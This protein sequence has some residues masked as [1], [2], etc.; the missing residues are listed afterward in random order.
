MSEG[1]K[2]DS[3]PTNVLRDIPDFRDRPYEPA[4]IQL[5]PQLPAPDDLH[6]LDQGTEGSCTGF[7]LAAV[8]NLLINPV[9]FDF[10]GSCIRSWQSA[11]NCPRVWNMICLGLMRRPVAFSNR[12][13]TFIDRS[14]CPPRSKKL[15]YTPI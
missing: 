11:D 8:I 9:G 4:L 14:E 7:G 6:I 12:A 1:N 13:I 5:K 10:W 3:I 15:S 2:I